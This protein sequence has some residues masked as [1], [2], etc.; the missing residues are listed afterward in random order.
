M[1]IVFLTY[2]MIPFSLRVSTLLCTLLSVAH[3]IISAVVAITLHI[4]IAPT[5]ILRQ[6]SQSL[7]VQPLSACV[8]SR[9]LALYKCPTFVDVSFT[10]RSKMYGMLFG[11]GNST[12]PVVSSSEYGWN[13]L[14]LPWRYSPSQ[15][16]LRDTAIHSVANTDWRAKGKEGV[17]ASFDHDLISLFHSGAPDKFTAA[18]HYEW[19]GQELSQEIW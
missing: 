11:T 6:V 1:F 17:V 16:I 13:I 18:L 14:Q 2:T 7:F 5:V 4:Q 12:Y 15:G 8:F 19:C 3:I 10:M 9:V